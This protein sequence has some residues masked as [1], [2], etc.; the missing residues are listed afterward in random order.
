MAMA[1]AAAAAA[2]AA[3]AAAG[4][5]LPTDELQ[6]VAQAA[7]N[8]VLSETVQTFWDA[9]RGPLF[10]RLGDH[11][12]TVPSWRKAISEHELVLEAIAAHD[13]NAARAAMQHHLDKAHARFS[14]SWRR[15]S[16]S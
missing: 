8:A 10:E 5:V 16:A 15:A 13:A 11:F 4:C 14:A 12:E 9:R 1:M 2:A 3:V 6:A 7:G